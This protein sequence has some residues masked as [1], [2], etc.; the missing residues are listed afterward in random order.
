M[1]ISLRRFAAGTDY[2]FAQEVA[3]PSDVISA[4]LRLRLAAQ[5]VH[6]GEIGSHDVDSRLGPSAHDR[7]DH[8]I[9]PDKG[10]E[11]AAERA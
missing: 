6:A 5:E 3:R 9:Q 11:D 2:R 4:R 7:A 8:L 1:C 10:T